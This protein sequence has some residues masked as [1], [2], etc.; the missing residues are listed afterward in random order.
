MGEPVWSRPVFWQAWAAI[1]GLCVAASGSRLVQRKNP[2]LVGPPPAQ[3]APRAAPQ[4]AF[5][6]RPVQLQQPNPLLGQLAAAETGPERCN[7]LGQLEA[8]EAP[9]IADAITGVLNNTQ[10]VSVRVCATQALG[11][12]RAPV[13]HSWLVDLANDPEPDVHSAALDI[14]AASE[15]QADQAA[16]VE[17]THDDDPDVRVSAASA[18]LKAGRAQAFAALATVLP[19]VEDRTTL[20]TLLNALGQSSDARALPVL[21]SLIQNADGDSHLTALSALSGLELPG[22]AERLWPLLEVGS[23][24]EFELAANR[25]GSL[26][27]APLAL[28]LRVLLTSANPERRRWAFG[29]LLN[30]DI[31]D[32]LPLMTQMLRSGDTASQSIVV[33]QLTMKPE[34]SFEPELIAFAQGDER[35][36][37]SQAFYA[38][39]QLD[40]PGAQAALE[41]LQDKPGRHLKHR[42]TKS[43]KGTEEEL[44]ARRIAQLESSDADAAAAL[45]ELAADHEPAAQAAAFRYVE[46]H[47]DAE[48]LARFA[49]LASTAN[50][51]KLLDHAD[52]FQPEQQRALIQ[53][54]SRRGDPQFS[55]VLR[56]ALHDQDADTRADALRGLLSLGDDSARAE[57]PRFSRGTE[58]SDRA[59]AAELLGTSTAPDAGAQLEALAQDPDPQVVSSALHSLQRQTPEQVE[60]LAERAFRA[61]APEDR[62]AL[63]NSIS[64][65]RSN[66]TRP[67]YDLAL[68]DT[69]DATAIQGL[70]A[71]TNL[72]GPESARRLLL[73][74]TDANRSQ[75]VRQEAAGGLRQLGGPLARANRALLDSLSPPEDSGAISCNL[76]Y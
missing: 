26:A 19:S 52:R 76:S 37:S 27:P 72:A 56:N 73:V 28:K 66:V 59:L 43:V 46:G 41:Q 36:L 45:P 30:L 18:L 69:D 63:L 42:L 47:E 16:V 61:A 20:E 25:L 54:L 12:Q 51:Q 38:L 32:R 29:Q 5:V 35:R 53:A 71:L 68:T 67:L 65:L 70:Q 33:Q 10:L 40:T 58:S 11:I 57:L 1:A 62:A 4:P 2:A 3:Q 13:A 31:P 21:D 44:R 34:P 64:D 60:R 24:Q 14:L 39:S 75:A 49:S 9:E 23:E 6:A 17:A 50:V 74:V 7:L 15:D 8:G 22:V 55:G 48:N